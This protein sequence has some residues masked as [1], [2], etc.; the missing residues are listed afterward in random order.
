[1]G[2]LKR[3][4]LENHPKC[5]NNLHFTIFGIGIL[6]REKNNKVTMLVLI[7]H[8]AAPLTLNLLQQKRLEKENRIDK[9]ESLL[10]DRIFAFFRLRM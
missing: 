1:M 7:M 2:R 9:A 4:V 6:F 3:F 10:C 5:K 8:S